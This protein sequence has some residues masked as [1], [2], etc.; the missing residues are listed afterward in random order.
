MEEENRYEKEGGGR[1][2][3]KE[4]GCLKKANSNIE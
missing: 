2:M 4:I 1:D 3:K